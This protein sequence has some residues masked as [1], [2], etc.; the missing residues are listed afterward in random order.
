MFSETYFWQ[1]IRFAIGGKNN[2]ARF[3]LLVLKNRQFRVNR[4][5]DFQLDVRQ[6]KQYC[7]NLNGIISLPLLQKLKS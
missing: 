1:N 3:N 5:F 6:K 7:S 2:T 4:L